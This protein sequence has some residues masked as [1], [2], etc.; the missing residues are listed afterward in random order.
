MVRSYFCDYQPFPNSVPWRL[1]TVKPPEGF[2]E[3]RVYRILFAKDLT[4]DG[5]AELANL[6]R[7]ALASDWPGPQTRVVGTANAQLPG[8]VFT[9]NLRRIGPGIAWCLDVTAQLENV[10]EDVL[11]EVLWQLRTAM[12][13]QG[14]IPV[15]IERFS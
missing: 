11:G 3:Q 9:W 14:L 2:V 7:M 4:A 6:W 5:V 10:R 8:H 12:R 1:S 15:T 13:R